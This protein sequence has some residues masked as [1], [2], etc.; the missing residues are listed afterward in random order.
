MNKNWVLFKLSMRQMIHQIAGSFGGKK[1][2][3]WLAFIPFIIMVVLSGFYTQSMLVS[4]PKELYFLIPF[5]MILASELIVMSFGFYHTQGYLFDFRDFDLLFSMP[6]TKSQIL[7]QKLISLMVMMLIYS[8]VLVGPMVVLYGIQTVSPVSYYVIALLGFLF[9]PIIPMVISSLFAVAIRFFSRG[10]KNKVLVR[11]LLSIGLIIVVLGGTMIIPSFIGTVVDMTGLLSLLETYIPPVYW[12]AMA[13]V[14]QDYQYLFQLILL[15][16]VV[17]VVFLVLFNKLWAM[18]NEKE[19]H[20]I[21]DKN[22][23][24]T[25]R[26]TSI[27]KAL[28]NKELK[29]YFSSTILLMNTLV[30]PIMVLIYT[31]GILIQKDTILTLFTSQG[32]SLDRFDNP[33]SALTMLVILFSTLLCSMTAS[34]ISLEGKNFWIVRSLPISTKYYL[35]AKAVTNM[36]L[37]VP[38]NIISVLLLSFALNFTFSQLFIN[39]LLSILAGVVVSLIGLVANLHF[40]RFDYDREVIVVK[41]SMSVMIA[42]FS[43]IILTAALVA[44]AMFIPL[45][46]VTY[47]WLALLLLA[48]LSFILCYYLQINAEKLLSSM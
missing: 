22:A 17:L 39:I 38:V 4:M 37:C 21:V 34:S 5:M 29:R 27:F 28:L 42:T 15:S 6:L 10:S 1:K 19:K 46:F 7:V 12:Y 26:S 9:M 48:I 33:F 35:G 47:C 23:K 11:N 32:I 8:F 14:Q 43:A 18:L 44:G 2:R 20:K 24:L 36:L 3:S 45:A 40:P 31:V 25:I 16:T 13:I 41:Q 30:G